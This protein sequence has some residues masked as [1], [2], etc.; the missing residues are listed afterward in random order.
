MPK[1]AKHQ[2]PLFWR[3]LKHKLSPFKNRKERELKISFDAIEKNL[4]R[5][6]KA[7]PERER[8]VARKRWLRYIETLEQFAETKVAR[9]RL[10]KISTNPELDEELR[11]N[12]H[13]IL[14]RWEEL[15]DPME[16]ARIIVAEPKVDVNFKK[17]RLGI[18]ATELESKGKR[19]LAEE[20]RKMERNLKA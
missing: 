9:E 16:K 17:A 7:L 20:I 12:A 18:L 15:L 6:F 4:P 1:I 14:R 10:L 2:R 11:D 5:G 13:R 8:E 19:E 3:K